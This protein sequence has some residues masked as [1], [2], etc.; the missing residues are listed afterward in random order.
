MVQLEA[1]AAGK[2]VISTELGTGTSYVNLHN[3]TGLVVSPA[4]SSALAGAINLLLSDVPRRTAM[5]R[6]GQQR[7]RAEFSLQQLYDR[8]E[9]CYEEVLNTGIR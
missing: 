3:Q 7:V 9:A 2:A 5:G 4:D 8:V 1:M 6:R